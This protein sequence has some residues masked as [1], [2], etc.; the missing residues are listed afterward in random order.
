VIVPVLEHFT[1]R[2]KYSLT[3]AVFSH[4]FAPCVYTV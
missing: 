3:V 4:K 2:L 1:V